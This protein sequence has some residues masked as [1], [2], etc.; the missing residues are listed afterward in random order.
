MKGTVTVESTVDVPGGS[1]LYYALL[2]ATPT[3]FRNTTKIHYSIAQ[4]EHVELL[5]FDAT[6]RLARSL[7]DEYVAKPGVHGA[8][9]NGRS[10]TGQQLPAGVYFYKM[11]AGEF[12]ATRRMIL[13]R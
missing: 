13:T 12:R 1:G 8:A 5:V 10:N 9:W 4:P 3:P 6:G 11:K 2:Q 7:V